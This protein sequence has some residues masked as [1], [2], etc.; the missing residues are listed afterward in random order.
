MCVTVRR[1]EGPSAVEYF[2]ACRPLDVSRPASEQAE[3]LYQ[4]LQ[5]VLGERGLGFASVVSEAVFL[6]D[7]ATELGAI[8]E[9]RQRVVASGTAPETRPATLEIEQP[10]LGGAALEVAAHVVAP[11]DGA[12]ARRV[13][14]SGGFRFQVDDGVFVGAGGIH[15]TG[16]GA[17][18]Q[19]LSMFSGAEKILEEADMSFRNVVRTW[20]HLREMERDYAELN[21]ARRDFFESRGIVAAPA[22]TGIGGGPVASGSDLCLSF[23]AVDAASRRRSQPMTTPTL[24]EAG[25][26][27]ADFARGMSVA[28][29]GRVALLISGTASVDE[30]GETAHVGDFEAQVDRMLV[31]VASLL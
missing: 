25:Q 2:V 14:G 30:A 1:V 6:R 5:G 15:G 24:N 8:R 28:T 31:N 22:S 10:P 13:F 9:A 12:L 19:A 17:Y 3:A 27:G 16:E 18:D 29:G 7:A 23:L 4:S 11:L 21:R 20:I 26:Y